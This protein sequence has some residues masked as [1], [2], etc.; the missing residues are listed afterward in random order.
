[1]INEVDVD[2]NGTLD[3]SE[4]TSLMV[5]KSKE[6]DTEAALID[7]F[8]VFDRDGNGLISSAELRHVITNIGEK[9][10][11]DEID[12]M[13]RDADIDGDGEINYVKF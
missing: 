10:T 8:K 13:I 1:M 2:G 6:I 5:R 4:F 11:D 7:A 3:F 12:E 9:L